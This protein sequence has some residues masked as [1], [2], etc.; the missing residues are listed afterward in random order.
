MAAYAESTRG[1]HAAFF[2]RCFGTLTIED[3]EEHRIFSL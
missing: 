3:V 1:K 2:K